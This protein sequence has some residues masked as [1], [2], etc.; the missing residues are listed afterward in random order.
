MSNH[1]PIPDL[2]P[3]LVLGSSSVYR[4]QILERLGLLCRQISP[5]VDES[6]F[7][8]ASPDALAGL[9]AEQKA[10]NVAGKVNLEGDWVVIGSDQVCHCE[11]ERFSKPGTLANARRHLAQFSGRWVTFSTGLCLVAS[12]G[13]TVREVEDFACLFRQLSVDEIDRYLELDS[14]LDCAGA[15]KAEAGGMALMADTRGRDINTLYGLPVMLLTEAF[16]SLG[17]SIFDF[18]KDR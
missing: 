5:D 9:L 16:T 18:N 15:I 17:L 4:R 14:P 7:T 13:R 6:G 12:D 1:F 8:A 11:G 2:M 3:T 10:L